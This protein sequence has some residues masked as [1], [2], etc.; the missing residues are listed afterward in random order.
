MS[1]FIERLTRDVPA[2][3]RQRGIAAVVEDRRI[4]IDMPE[5]RD[6]IGLIAGLFDELSARSF[7]WRFTWIDDSARH[8]QRDLPD[9]ETIL[10]DKNDLRPVSA[11]PR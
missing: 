5:H 7:Q 2:A 11:P 9:T 6:R 4:G 3:E 1:S 10:F 8:L